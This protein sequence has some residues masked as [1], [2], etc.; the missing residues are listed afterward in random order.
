MLLL[1]LKVEG[2]DELGELALDMRKSWNHTA[3]KLWS[4]LYRDLWVLTH[5]PWVV[6][7][8]VSRDRRTLFFNMNIRPK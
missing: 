2:F 4:Q 8:T 5:N 6:L 1:A 3:D 7:Q